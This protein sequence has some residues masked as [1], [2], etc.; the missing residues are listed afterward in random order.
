MSSELPPT[1]Y[2]TNISFNPDFYQSSSSEYLTAST[3]RNYF[4][5]YPITQGSEIFTNNITLQSTLTDSLSSVGTS[6]QL[7]SSTGTGTSWIDNMGTT[8]ISYSASATLSLSVNPILLVI[9]S[10]STA[11][12]TLTIPSGYPVGQ[13]IQIKST[14]T[15][16][17]SISSGSVP[18]FL[19]G[20][21]A[22]TT[23]ITLIPSDVINLVYSGSSWVQYAPSNTFTKIVGANGCIAG[24]TNYVSINT[25]A[26][27]QTLSTVIN[28]DLFVF[29]AGS[30]ASKTLNIPTIS[31]TGQT[32]TI[33]NTSSVSVNIAFP[34]SNIMLFSENSVLVPLMVLK[35]KEV[36][37]MYWA[38]AFWVQTTPSNTMTELISKG[39]ITAMADLNLNV[40][41]NLA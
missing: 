26:L 13:K 14:A 9:F 11:G 2:F 32:I 28:T 33:K 8:Y 35:P 6:G 36:L 40:N 38:S 31:N 17:V 29:L 3:G 16:N 1:D 34:T 41:L 24:Q 10:G 25:S 5:T 27:P 12:Q 30:T 15:V 18:T 23:S 20:V 37:S 39:D 22:S 21:S 7:L 4:L 19:Y